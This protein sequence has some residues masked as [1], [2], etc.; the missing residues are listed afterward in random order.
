MCGAPKPAVPA[1]LGAFRSNDPALGKALW[2][3][4]EPGTSTC[5]LYYQVEFYLTD[6]LGRRTVTF[7]S[8][9]SAPLWITPPV[10][11]VEFAL[12]ATDP[13]DRAVWASYSVFTQTFRARAFT[14]G[15][16]MSLWSDFFTFATADCVAGQACSDHR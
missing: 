4:R 15:G 10:G 16:S 11:A 3:S 8:T 2:I 1:P 5:P 9:E 13:G 7:Q 12:K 6:G 14:A